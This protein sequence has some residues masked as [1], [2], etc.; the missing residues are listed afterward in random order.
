MSRN[1]YGLKIVDFF[2]FLVGSYGSKDAENI[3]PLHRFPNGL[4]EELGCPVFSVP[5]NNTWP[6]ICKE[7]AGAW[8]KS[9]KSLDGDGIDVVVT[10]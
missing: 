7:S 1:S 3:S 4:S 6:K 9:S 2:E 10:R 5:G 8:A